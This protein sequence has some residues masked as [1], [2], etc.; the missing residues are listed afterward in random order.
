MSA[1]SRTKPAGAIEAMQHINV[2]VIKTQFVAGILS[3]A[4][5]SVLFAIYSLM[6]FEGAALATILIAPLVYLPSV[7]FTTMFGN[8]PMNNNL[9]S[10][11][12]KSA[13]AEAYWVVYVRDWTR[14]NHARAMGSALTSGLYIIAAIT[15][16][17]SEQV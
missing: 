5:F 3:I 15:L 13:E 6:V 12:H 2:T 7:F 4:L 8:V 17:T 9:D 1:L 14:L 16:I 10:L 11:D